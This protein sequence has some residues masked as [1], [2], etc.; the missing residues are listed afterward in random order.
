MEGQARKL[1]NGTGDD[2]YLWDAST[3]GSCGVSRTPD[4]GDPPAVAS[5]LARPTYSS[6]VGPAD[7]SYAFALAPGETVRLLVKNPEGENRVKG[8][9]ILETR[10]GLPMLS[11][12]LRAEAE[13]EEGTL[14]IKVL[15]SKLTAE[16]SG[17]TVVVKYPWSRSTHG[18]GA[19]PSRLGLWKDG[20]GAGSGTEGA[21]SREGKGSK[22]PRTPHYPG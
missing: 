21:G 5:L 13:K 14:G 20:Q 15:N 1:T 16:P 3:R 11:L 17:E 18:A 4:P 9:F 22:A 8:T 19:G 7:Y 10:V 12:E 6:G 2:L